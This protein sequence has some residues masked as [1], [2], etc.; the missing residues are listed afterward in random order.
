MSK[1]NIRRGGAIAAA[2]VG[3]ALLLAGCA[4]Q[5][6]TD[7]APQDEP[8]QP[9][10]SQTPSESGQAPSEG[11]G[12][13]DQGGG[14]ASQGGDLATETFDVSWQD[15]VATAQ[16]AFDGRLMGVELDREGGEYFYTVDLASD[17]EEYEGHVHA[18]TGELRG[19]ETEPLDSDDAAEVDDEVFEVDGLVEPSEAIAAALAE[20]DGTATSWSLDRGWAGIHYDIDVDLTSGDDAEVEVD[21]TT[22]EVVEVD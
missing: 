10:D 16:Q 5:A 11:Q 15:A 8:R 18:T 6:P 7:S 3:T 22:G 21:A 4:T 12:G 14:S 13:E 9:A 17:T 19:E 2:T 1:T 20:V